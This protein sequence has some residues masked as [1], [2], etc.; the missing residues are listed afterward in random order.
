MRAFNLPLSLALV[1]INTT[2]EDV[3]TGLSSIPNY[4]PHVGGQS[5]GQERSDRSARPP[6][7]F[8]RLFAVPWRPRVGVLVCVPLA[9]YFVLKLIE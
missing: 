8:G 7:H 3:C 5:G 2:V 6:P 9:H 4:T 1:Y